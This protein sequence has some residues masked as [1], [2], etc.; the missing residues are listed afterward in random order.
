MK[1][2]M[3]HGDVE[4]TVDDDGR[5]RVSG[6][7]SVSSTFPVCEDRTKGSFI[8]TVGQGLW[9]LEI[10]LQG[11]KASPLGKARPIALVVDTTRGPR[12]VQV[13]AQ[14]GFDYWTVQ[15]TLFPLR[16]SRH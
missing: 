14:D 8:V 13:Y 5:V 9:K 6:S 11:D 16:E 12:G 1:R 3:H 2:R 4:V 7:A 10:A 15:H